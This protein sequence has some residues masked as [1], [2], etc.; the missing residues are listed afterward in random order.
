MSE[1]FQ[2]QGGQEIWQ[3]LNGDKNVHY[4]DSVLSPAKLLFREATLSFDAGAHAG[5][6]VLCRSALEAGC[7]LFLTR[8]EILKEEASFAS[9]LPK[10][11]K[12]GS[13]FS[14][15]IPRSLTG[16]PRR[17]HWDELE[18]AI[19]KRKILSKDQ[20][21][22]LRRIRRRG[23]IVAH[24]ASRR[25]LSKYSLR[26]RKIASLWI[27][28]EDALED[29]RDASD[30]LRRLAY[31]FAFSPE[32]VFSGPLRKE[33]TITETFLTRSPEDESRDN[34]GTESNASET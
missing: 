33:I 14:A 12:L 6:S 10:G 28:R 27:N 22:N 8:G 5:A 20:L 7:Y 3:D 2:S 4:L 1:A 30:I 23:N 11:V 29:L 19:S 18:R 16:F 21:K 9:E 31:L 13:A 25:D 17:V 26:S 15:I 24:L 34:D 32:Y